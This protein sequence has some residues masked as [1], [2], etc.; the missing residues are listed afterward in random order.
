[1]LVVVFS[2]PTCDPGTFPDNASRSWLL[3]LSTQSKASPP[4]QC[5]TVS[6]AGRLD[7]QGGSP[8]AK[9]TPGASVGST[10][11]CW[12]LA[13]SGL[14]AFLPQGKIL[15]VLKMLN[16]HSGVSTP[17]SLALNTPLLKTLCSQRYLH[18]TPGTPL[19]LLFSE[20]LQTLPRQVTAPNARCKHV[21]QLP[22]S[23]SGGHRLCPAR[24]GSW[25]T[26]STCTTL[27]KE[28]P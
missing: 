27:Q 16:C 12:G 17:T 6:H 5:C 7:Q 13:A 23:S 20:S 15:S 22:C 11:M 26:S 2:S 9:A 24:F 21:T 10:V 19:V 14:L 3:A 8:C 18:Y 1:M 25:N 4:E 28:N